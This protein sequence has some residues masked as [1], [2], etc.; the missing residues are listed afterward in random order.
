MK[1]LKHITVV[2]LVL[3]GVFALS[4]SG[5]ALFAQ[6]S[7]FYDKWRDFQD[8]V[9]I[10]NTNYVE[11]VDWDKTMIGAQNGLMEALDPHSVYIGADRMNQINESFRGN[12]E[13]IG[14]EFDI[15][16]DYITVITPIVGSPS[17]GLLYPGDQIVKIDEASAYKITRDSVFDRLRGPKGSKVNLEIA[18]LGEPELIP[19]TI[20][21]D[22]IPIYSVLAKFVMDDDTGYILLNRFSS[23]TSNEV[24]TA[25]SE[26]QDQG[27]K[28]LIIDLRNNSGGYMDEVV[29]IVDHILPGGEK[30]LS[31]KGRLK[32]ANEE[33]YSKHKPTYYKQPII[34]MINRGSASASEILAGALQDLD[35]GM[36]VG[37][38]SFGKGLVQRQY[39]LR[40]GS[41]VRVTV[42][43]YYTPSGRLIQREYKNGEAQ[44][45][46]SELY[47]KDYGKD[48]TG[49]EEKPV[50][51]TKMGRT[52]YGGGG[53][54][55]DLALAD[56]AT[57]SR[58]LAKLRR[59]DIRFF[60]K[61][62]SD[63]AADHPELARDWDKFFKNYIVE[64]SLMNEVYEKIFAI[65]EL[66]L[67][68]EKIRED[69]ETIR[70][71]IKSE[72]AAKLWGRNEQYQVRTEM[73]N[74]IQEARQ[75]FK[76]AREI[77]EAADYL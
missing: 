17:D 28:R 31:T 20:F 52:V 32:N 5:Q 56:A 68:E 57:I 33:M 60:F 10:I 30:I 50:Y 46:Y 24:I 55:P 19:V 39:P 63:Y 49:L 23:T 45:Y 41:A 40:D 51:Q 44:D 2:S 66:E 64:A 26:L 43:R 38:T 61:I 15:I 27:M 58:D 25:I 65:E 18:R 42:A 8:M 72:L 37:E 74:Q 12:F 7:D 36:V 21:R 34:A 13:G 47:D 6:G 35:R 29:K 71:Y 76:K 1:T 69:D 11:D 14:I 73:D 67:D 48:T 16:D 70:Y 22:K 4:P 54:T 59:H 77:A 53:I 75:H 3:L 9:K 62:A